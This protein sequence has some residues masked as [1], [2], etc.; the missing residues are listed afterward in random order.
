MAYPFDVGAQIGDLSAA[1]TV[2]LE[3]NSLVR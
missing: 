1:Q 2:F 3:K